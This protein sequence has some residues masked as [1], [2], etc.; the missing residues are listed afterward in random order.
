MGL[1]KSATVT[2]ITLVYKA[3]YFMLVIECVTS[4]PL[5]PGTTVHRS[6]VVMVHIPIK[7]DK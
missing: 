3:L 2:I 4:F 1:K 6:A 7:D 5:L